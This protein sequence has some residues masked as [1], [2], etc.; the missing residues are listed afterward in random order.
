MDRGARGRHVIAHLG[1]RLTRL[2]NWG[3]ENF[4]E[5]TRRDSGSSPDRDPPSS[6]HELG[7]EKGLFDDKR[8]GDCSSKR[9]HGQ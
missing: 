3:P 9:E 2:G 5:N 1:D 8:A 4:H 6:R 7:L